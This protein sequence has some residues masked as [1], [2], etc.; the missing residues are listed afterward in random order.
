MFKEYSRFDATALAVLIRNKAVS[1]REVMKQHWKKPAT[2]I[3]PLMRSHT[4]FPLKLRLLKQKNTREVY[5]PDMNCPVKG[6]P[7]TLGSALYKGHVWEF[8]AELTRRY[9]AA[10]LTILGMT[11]VPEFGACVSSESVLHGAVHNPHK[12]GKTAGGSSGGSAAAVAA[13]IVRQH[14][15]VT[16]A[17]LSVFRHRVAVSSD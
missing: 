12:H 14:M 6:M 8:D 13:G 9:K 2:S 4:S 17:D 11:N 10:G 7:G 5:L 16:A 1:V 3:L 15:P